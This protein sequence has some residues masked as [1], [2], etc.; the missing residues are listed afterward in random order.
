MLW[1]SEQYVLCSERVIHFRKESKLTL[2]GLS[3]IDS[4]ILSADWYKK[5]DFPV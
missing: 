1:T 5:P 3:L 4:L 2:F